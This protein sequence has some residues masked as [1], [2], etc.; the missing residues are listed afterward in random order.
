MQGPEIQ[1][2][3]DALA[4]NF[5]LLSQVPNSAQKMALFPVIKARAYGLGS[6]E[7]AKE[8]ERRFDDNRMPYLCVARW[9][10]AQ[11]LREN[12][13]N[14]PLLILSQFSLPE[15]FE[16]PLE[17]VSLM[18]GSLGD[19]ENLKKLSPAHKSQIRSL[20]L[21]LDTGMNRCGFKIGAPD[22][23]FKSIESLLEKVASLN[24]PVDGIATHLAKGEEAPEI[25]SQKQ[26]QLFETYLQQIKTFWNQYFKS[27]FPKWIHIN[28]S[29]GASR[30]S[31]SMETARRPGILLWGAHQNSQTRLKFE[32]EFPHLKFKEVLSLKTPLARTFEVDAGEGVGY[33]HRF[34]SPQKTRIG[35]LNIGYA[36][37]LSRSLSTDANNFRKSPLQFSIEGEFVPIVGTVSMDMVM[38]DLG[39]HSRLNQ[40]SKKVANGELCWATWIGSEQ[41]VEKHADV[42]NTISYEI[43]CALSSRIPRR[44]R[45]S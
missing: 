19:L 41:P 12:G 5:E 10:E 23:D 37:G 9:N 31:N 6:L 27:S 44:R 4:S 11:F 36:D 2:D 8:L 1:L 22:V 13:I 26:N 28:N 16:T 43:L 15:F 38:I 24:I 29:S 18:L 45:S 33:G 3:F 14:R 34:V 32:S 35:L 17:N 21:E 30:N 7:I 25:Y 40:I 20:H 39:S 42:L